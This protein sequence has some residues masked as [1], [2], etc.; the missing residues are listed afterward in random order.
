MVWDP[1][2]ET[3]NVKRMIIGSLIPILSI[4]CCWRIQKFW[5]I[6]SIMFFVQIVM[7]IVVGMVIGMGIS[8]GYLD[9]GQIS[10]GV[11]IGLNLLMNPLLFR[12]YAQEYNKKIMNGELTK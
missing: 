3:V 10:Y 11:G 4:Y 1:K 9:M 8:F 6:Y 12:Y 7:G 5:V 2:P